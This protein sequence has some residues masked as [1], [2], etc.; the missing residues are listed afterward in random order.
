MAELWS[1]IACAQCLCMF[2]EFFSIIFLS[3]L[4][5]NI[6]IKSLS[7]LLSIIKIKIRKSYIIIQL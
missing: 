1:L 6:V 5:S 2:Y 4:K 7:L 3:G